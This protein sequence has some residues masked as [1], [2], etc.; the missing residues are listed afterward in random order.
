MLS[1]IAFSCLCMLYCLFQSTWFRSLLADIL[2]LKKTIRIYIIFPFLL[3]HLSRIIS[4]FP[5]RPFLFVFSHFDINIFNDWPFNCHIFHFVQIKYFQNF[6]SEISKAILWS[7]NIFLSFN[8]FLN[9]QYISEKLSFSFKVFQFKFIIDMLILQYLW[10][11]FIC[12]I[13]FSVVWLYVHTLHILA[14]NFDDLGTSKIEHIDRGI[15]CYL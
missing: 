2:S 6:M 15:I 11:T 12:Y 13:I 7:N 5:W 4:G 8:S 3:F 14:L 10:T 1:I 9:P